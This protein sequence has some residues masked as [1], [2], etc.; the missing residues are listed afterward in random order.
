VARSGL[1]RNLQSD[2]PYRGINQL[3]LQ[4][5]QQARGYGSPFWTTYRAAKKAGGHVRRGERGTTVVFWRMLTVRADEDDA[6]VE[7]GEDEAARRFP[8]ARPYTVFNADQTE[9]LEV[10]ELAEPTAADFEPV[11]AAER[12]IAEMPSPP[13]I[14]HGAGGAWYDPALDRVALPETREFDPS[15]GYYATAFH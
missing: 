8:F 7:P 6:S 13:E 4:V 15:A 1:Q 2:R 5:R 10:P 14:V 12:V 3:L 9:G 11:D